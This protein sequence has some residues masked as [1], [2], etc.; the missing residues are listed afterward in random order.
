MKHKGIILLTSVLIMVVASGLVTYAY[1]Y[2]FITAYW[3][4]GTVKKTTDYESAN[5]IK[6]N[7][8]NAE[9]FINCNPFGGDTKLVAWVENTSGNNITNKVTHT[10]ASSNT[11]GTKA[12]TFASSPS[13][14]VG[15]SMHLNVS[16]VLTQFDT[17]E[18]VGGWSPDKITNIE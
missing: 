12:M 1:D 8:T 17:R 5:Q 16:T 9:A 15:T 7:T 11:D 3:I 13:N 2:L 14:Y 4:E 6:Q 18:I 10:F